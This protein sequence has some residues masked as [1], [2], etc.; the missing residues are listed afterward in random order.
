MCLEKKR[1]NLQYFFAK[2]SFQT[3]LISVIICKCFIRIML[4]NYKCKY[5]TPLLFYASNCSVGT[6]YLAWLQTFDGTNEGQTSICGLEFRH[7]S[8][9]KEM[10]ATVITPQWKMSNKISFS[11]KA[12]VF[13]LIVEHESHFKA[14]KNFRKTTVRIDGPSAWEAASVATQLI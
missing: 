14:V 4:I 13:L 2:N 9:E 5:F 1:L 3:R 6:G 11:F 12:T 8:I 10:A 7:K